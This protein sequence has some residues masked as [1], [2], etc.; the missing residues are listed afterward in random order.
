[1]SST[2]QRILI[3]GVVVIAGIILV[4]SVAM[5]Q[6]ASPPPPSELPP[7]V[8]MTVQLPPEI[9][10]LLPSGPVATPNPDATW[11]SVG[12]FTG[13]EAGRTPAFDLSGGLAR[14]HYKVEG[15]LPF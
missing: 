10:N 7:P 15:D 5:P 8:N 12:E 13:T 4:R 9:A 6:Q 14:V 1:M 11:V 3:I 2:A